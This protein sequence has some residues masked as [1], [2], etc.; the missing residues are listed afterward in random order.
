MK[1]TKDDI[2]KL[3]PN[4]RIQIEAELEKDVMAKELKY[5][6]KIVEYQG[7]K[8]RSIRECNRYKILKYHESLK[9]IKNLRLQ[10]RYQL[11]VDSVLIESYDADFV[12]TDTFTG[13]EIVEDC[14]GCRTPTYKRKKK[15]MKK[16]FGIE[17]KET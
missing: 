13:N 15:W 11:I 12:Y 6:N 8:F 2:A 1:F 5:K 4:I 3:P 17:I 16:V 7:I 10:V 9:V 14:K